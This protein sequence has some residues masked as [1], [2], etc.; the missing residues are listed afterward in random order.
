MDFHRHVPLNSPLSESRGG[1]AVTTL[2]AGTAALLLFGVLA[3]AEFLTTISYPGVI[4]GSGSIT[5]YISSGNDI[6]GIFGTAGANLIGDSVTINYVYSLGYSSEPED[7]R[8]FSLIWGE[9]NGVY[10][11]YGSAGGVGIQISIGSTT[12][13]DGGFAMPGTDSLTGFDQNG[14]PTG[15][16][17]DLNALDYCGIGQ[18]AQLAD[19]YQEPQCDEDLS[20]NFDPSGGTFTINP[21]D[22]PQSY[23][24][25]PETAPETFTFIASPEPSTFAL[26]GIAL[27]G[28]ALSHRHLRQ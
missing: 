26:I 5:G 1:K 11:W 12:V 14:N 4:D 22:V 25:N 20:L 28:L 27:F 3:R 18:Y 8:I 21:F 13:T 17:L 2:A 10:G 15:A 6:D 19:Q 7:Y 23:P 16:P 24:F 9:N